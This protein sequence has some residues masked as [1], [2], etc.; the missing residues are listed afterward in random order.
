MIESS[1]LLN[2]CLPN[3]Y[4]S[5]QSLHGSG[6]QCLFCFTIL[7]RPPRDLDVR[8]LMKNIAL[9]LLAV[10]N[11]AL[12]IIIFRPI[13]YGKPTLI[14]NSEFVN[15]TA[16]ENFIF[17]QS[18][19]SRI[20]ISVH[21]YINGIE[22]ESYSTALNGDMFSISRNNNDYTIKAGK[23]ISMKMPVDLKR[24]VG[25]KTTRLESNELY[26]LKNDYAVYYD[27]YEHSSDNQVSGDLS[28]FEKSIKKS[29]E[30]SLSDT[31]GKIKANQID[32]SGNRLVVIVNYQ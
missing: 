13:G 22:M 16:F 2:F 5:N 23:V 19:S 12:L 24:K 30:K 9:F 26:I 3:R 4:I 11:I 7:S 18:I 8:S 31:F 1:R 17:N 28:D 14:C 20:N 21:K 27:I 15:D 32:R 29:V 10:S 6:P 25:S